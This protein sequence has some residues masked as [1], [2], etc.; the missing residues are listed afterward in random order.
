[1]LDV[2]GL[3]STLTRTLRLT[4]TFDVDSIVDIDLGASP[5]MPRSWRACACVPTVLRSQGA[6]SRVGSDVIVAVNVEVRVKVI[7]EVIV[8]DKVKCGRPVP[9]HS[10]QYCPD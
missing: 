8:E 10:A 6:R 2:D 5:S 7:V 9:R 4:A 1:V 3:T